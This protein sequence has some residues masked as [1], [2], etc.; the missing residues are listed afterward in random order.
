[1]KL[2]DIEKFVFFATLA[3]LFIPLSVNIRVIN[4]YVWNIPAIA[5][6]IV[7]FLQSLYTGFWKVQKW[8]LWD[9]SLIGLMFVLIIFSMIGANFM[10]NLPFLTQYI[11]ILFMAFYARRA[12]GRVI[13]PKVLVSFAL[14]SVFIQSVIGIIQQLTFSQFGNPK[15]YFGRGQ[16]TELRDSFGVEISRV[17]GTL[18]HPNLVGNWF[19][20]LFPFLIVSDF[21]DRNRIAWIMKR[22]A[23]LLGFIGLLFTLSRGNIAF[24]SLLCVLFILPWLRLISPKMWS[25]SQVLTR[26]VFVIVLTLSLLYLI[27]TNMEAIN[28]YYSVL[29]DRIEQ[30]T[31]V[32]NSRGTADF[33]LEMNKGALQKVV[34]QKFILGN[35]FNNSRNIWSDVDT[36]IPVWWNYRPHNVYLALAVEGG[37][38]AFI[39]YIIITCLPIYYLYRKVN[40]S[41]VLK[42]AF[43]F[44][45]C[46]GFLFG[47]I[48]LTHLSPEYGVLYSLI[49][50]SS[51]GYIDEISAMSNSLREIS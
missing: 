11:T 2:R 30:A 4:L 35:G 42:Y 50:G 32:R 19:I 36:D 20:T 5:L 12:W 22:I 28:T 23:V 21:F 17:Q 3:G 10:N 34:D 6:M 24:F 51:M 15:A 27:T 41:E 9:Y 48:Y 7:V 26:T 39:F 46:A 37:I 31:S 14:I 33:R 13:T 47:Q 38:F 45:L 18:G 1:M 16:S 25:S 49:L 44:A 29:G 43:L 8:D 40:S